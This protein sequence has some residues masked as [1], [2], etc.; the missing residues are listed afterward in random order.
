MTQDR[1]VKI[2]ENPDLLSSI[3][4][5]ELKTL[6]LTYPYAHNLRYLLA[7]KSAQEDHPDLTRNLSSA[8]TYSL[9][10]YCL[11]GLVAP[12]RYRE[13][14]TVMEPEAVLELKPIELLQRELESK[15]PVE[16]EV[17]P[18]PPD[19]PAQSFVVEQTVNGNTAHVQTAGSTLA[20]MPAEKMEDSN[21]EE[22][23]EFPN[24]SVWISQFNPPV[25]AQQNIAPLEDANVEPPE[26]V[27]SNVEASSLEKGPDVLA[28]I[29]A[30]Q[31]AEK[32]VRENKAILSETLARLYV[33]QGYL[34]KAVDMYERLGLAFPDKS[35]Y[36]AAEIDKLKK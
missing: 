25:L 11:F 15:A 3:P 7:L 30:Q 23:W 29:T 17:A 36:F 28:E 1:L 16:Q 10:R 20:A 12:I 33:E 27:D 32:S 21:G 4:Y 24:F 14:L 9:D 2:L 13:A 34:D 19:S 18:M 6:A 26:P 5:E 22:V 31:L 8:A 35:A